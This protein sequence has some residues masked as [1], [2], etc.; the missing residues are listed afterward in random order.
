M[1]ATQ[2]S[3]T[4][5]DS[6]HAKDLVKSLDRTGS[7]AQLS[8]T[9]PT[10]DAGKVA[11]LAPVSPALLTKIDCEEICSLCLGLIRFIGFFDIGD[12]E[13]LVLFQSIYSGTGLC[14]PESD[15]K[16]EKIIRETRVSDCAFRAQTIQRVRH[17][18]GRRYCF[19][20][21]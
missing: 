12:G 18:S 3:I 10:G 4:A 15:F 19:D 6:P 11:R 20:N 21:F 1:H 7:L 16:L 5:S 2:N 8:S 9:T 17:I 14:L 13:R